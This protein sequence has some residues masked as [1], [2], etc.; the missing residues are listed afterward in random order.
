MVELDACFSAAPFARL[1]HFLGASET[2]GTKKKK[3]IENLI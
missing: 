1:F 2:K 3:K